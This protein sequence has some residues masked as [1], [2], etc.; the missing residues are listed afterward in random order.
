MRMLV[1]AEQ[2]YMQP[3]IDAITIA[4]QQIFNRDDAVIMN[5]YQCYLKVGSQP[6]ICCRTVPPNSPKD[7]ETANP[8]NASWFQL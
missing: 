2:S 4:L 5:T 8:F 1:D 6:Y 7:R 3:A